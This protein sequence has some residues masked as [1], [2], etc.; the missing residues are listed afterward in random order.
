[1]DEDQPAG[2]TIR[3]DHLC[4]QAKKGGTSLGRR[5]PPSREGFF[6]MEGRQASALG[7][8]TLAGVS[9]TSP[10]FERVAIN[11][12]ELHVVAPSGGT[13]RWCQPFGE[14]EWAH[15]PLNSAVP[16]KGFVAPAER[17]EGA[18]SSGGD[19]SRRMRIGHRGEGEGVES[20]A[21]PCDIFS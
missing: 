19:W 13:A 14:T 16:T 17:Q 8:A 7:R 9:D 5:D 20:L 4:G 21:R 2:V 6:E 1:M 3:S 11:R 12:R 10:F 18:T 15:A